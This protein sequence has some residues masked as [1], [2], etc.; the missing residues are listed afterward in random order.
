LIDLEIW[1]VQYKKLTAKK[2]KLPLQPFSCIVDH[3]RWKV[4]N[5]G[6][7]QPKAFVANTRL[8]LQEKLLTLNLIS[9]RKEKELITSGGKCAILAIRSQKLLSQTPG[10]TCRKNN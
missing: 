8:H 1:T 2:K 5:F 10:F 3:I 6:H 7:V 4:C 9:L